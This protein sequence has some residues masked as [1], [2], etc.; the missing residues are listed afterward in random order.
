M[1]VIKEPFKGLYAKVTDKPGDELLINYFQE[2]KTYEGR[3]WVLEWKDTRPREDL[4]FV[5]G[6]NDDRE[7]FTFENV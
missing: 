4:K 6:I 3:Y 1:Q 2:K 7:R 5:L